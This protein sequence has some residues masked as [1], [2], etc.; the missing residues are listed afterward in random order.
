MGKEC[1]NKASRGAS[2]MMKVTSR[3]TLGVLWAC[4][5]PE[6]MPVLPDSHVDMFMCLCTPEHTQTHWYHCFCMHVLA[7]TTCDYERTQARKGRQAEV[8]RESAFRICAS[9]A[10]SYAS[11]ASSNALYCTFHGNLWL[12]K[13]L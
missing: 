4:A 11:V 6:R 2:K 7:C 3:C 13:F 1:I 5:G 10:S 9:A 12:N 8:R